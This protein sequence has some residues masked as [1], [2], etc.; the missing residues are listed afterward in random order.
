MA[1]TRAPSNRLGS[2][3]ARRRGRADSW[4][5]TGTGRE[6]RGNHPPTAFCYLRLVRRVLYS[7]SWPPVGRAPSDDL[8]R[9]DGIYNPRPQ[10]GL[11]FLRAITSSSR[12]LRCRADDVSSFPVDTPH[13]AARVDFSERQVDGFSIWRPSWPSSHGA[14]RWS[15]RPLTMT[16]RRPPEARGRPSS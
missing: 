6:R 9:P 16:S 4:C 2:G 12:I 3:K 14:R 1:P 11:P 8:L 10:L 15:A 13:R 5:L 7:L